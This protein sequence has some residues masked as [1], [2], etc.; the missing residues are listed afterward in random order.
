MEVGK[1][2]PYNA[3]IVNG[4]FSPLGLS[5]AILETEIQTASNFLAYCLAI[6]VSHTLFI[7]WDLI[8]C[9]P[10][11]LLFFTD[12]FPFLYLSLFHLLS[13]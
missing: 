11:H 13:L 9:H 5:S 8:L 4:L 12:L 10:L 1:C 3:G 2:L 6:I 7:L